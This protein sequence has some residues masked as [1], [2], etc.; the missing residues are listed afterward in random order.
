MPKL[1][2]QKCN[3]QIMDNDVSQSCIYVNIFLI[4]NVYVQR[5]QIDMLYFRILL[6]FIGNDIKGNP[7]LLKTNRFQVC[8]FLF[9]VN[10]KMSAIILLILIITLYFWR[11]LRRT[12][13]SFYMVVEEALCAH[14]AGPFREWFIVRVIV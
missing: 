11:S 10:S 4:K 12:K 6:T 3:L 7:L 1:Y 5:L 8:S 13:S 2:L 14:S 9:R